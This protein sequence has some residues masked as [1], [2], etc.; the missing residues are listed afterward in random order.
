MIL[1]L[2]NFLN[3]LSAMKKL[4]VLSFLSLLHCEEISTES[5]IQKPNV[6]LFYMDDLRPELSSFGI[7]QIQSPNIDA[8]AAKGVKFTNA[9]C[10]IPVCGASRASM[11]TGMLP[12]KD[13]FLD[14]N[15]FAENETPD[16]ISLPQLF[17][18]NG[19]TTISNGKIYHHLDDRE[20]DWDEVWR[21]YA[22]D[23]N[24]I[25][26]AP[27]D[28][29]QSLWKDYH[30]PENIAIYKNTDRGPAYESAE[31]VDSTYI[32]GLMAEKI[33]RDIKKL[34]K[35]G[36]PFFLTAGFISPHLPFNAP[37]KYWE[38][39]DRNEIKQPENYNYVPI[40]APKMSISNWPEMRSYTNI[41]KRG[42]VS[43]SIAIDLIHGYYATVSYSDA[44][45]GKILAALKDQG[46]D[47]N[48]I[49]VLVSDHG[50]NLQE[51]TQWAKFTNYN[52]ST[53]VPLI[54]YNPLAKTKGSTDALTELVDVYPTLTEICGLR[55][56]VDQLD[57]TS[58]VDI[59]SNPKLDGKNHIF[60][61]RGKGF[62]LK[63]NDFSYTEFI[64]P[65]DNKT[66][67]SMLYDHRFNKDENINVVNQKE[68]SEVVSKLKTTLHTVYQ[69]NITGNL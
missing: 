11:L 13:R 30:N 19:Y 15:T 66:V 56:P 3:N 20:T 42:Q 47:K 60:I 68:F 16:A 41:P 63:T 24:D 31:V 29:W 6:L 36:T 50:Y 7:A 4:F 61:K 8:L 33:I 45:I 53:Q 51:H 67:A 39:Y 25:G 10:N 18:K 54:I 27:T 57:G 59:M 5:N 62:T 58:L 55:P 23:D 17:K 26:L 64:R 69:K 43:D 37:T 1:L 14:Y 34:K 35:N 2:I 46:L 32:D 28:Y 40:N 48:T 22:F 44:L 21:P 38:L 12:T 49:V 9:Y 52:T 65:A